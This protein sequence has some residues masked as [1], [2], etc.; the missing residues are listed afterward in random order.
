VAGV[1]TKTEKNA[2]PLESVVA[3]AAS[4]APPEPLTAL[5]VSPAAGEPVLS[6]VSVTV[7]IEEPPESTLDG[8]ASTFITILLGELGP[9]ELLIESA[10]PHPVKIRINIK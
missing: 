6:K 8:F 4:S 3:V 1:V 2:W 10:V 9:E 5:T 7:I